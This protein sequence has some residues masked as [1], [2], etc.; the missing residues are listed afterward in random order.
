M[1]RTQ[2]WDEADALAAA[3]RVFRQRGYAGASLRELED[4]T[5]VH[6]GS[7]YRRFGDK[8]G[9]F[10]A[11]LQSYNTQ[12]VDQRVRTHLLT[13]EDPLTGI[14]SFFTSTFEELVDGI[15]GCLVT[16]S[17]VECVTLDPSVHGDVLDGLQRIE[18]GLVAALRRADQ[19]GQL[20]A[21]REPSALAA[22]LLAL[23]QGVLVLVRC[24]TPAAKLAAI[25]H[26]GVDALVGTTTPS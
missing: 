15:P 16:N 25:A 22:Q 18:D 14:R 13:A 26:G 3:R 23:Y 24:G 1:G 11:A 17:A 12:V 5:G 10:L 7:L 9:L 20:P 6:P 19:A 8:R 21:G 2:T 4:A